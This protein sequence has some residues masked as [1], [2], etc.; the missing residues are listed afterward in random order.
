MPTIIK[1]HTAS[2]GRLLD[3]PAVME[4][5]KMKEKCIPG[6]RSR[7]FTTKSEAEARKLYS[8]FYGKCLVKLEP[9]A[10]SWTNEWRVKFF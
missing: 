6:L 3:P 2:V 1:T 9:P 10:N 7:E 5:N 8:E 4:G